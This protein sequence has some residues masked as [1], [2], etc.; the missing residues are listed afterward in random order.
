MIARAVIVLLAVVSGACAPRLMKLPAGPGAPA[1]D[2]SDALAEA[3][4]ACR[5]ATT[6]TAEIAV[7]GSA[8]GQRVRGRLLAGVG[9]PSSARIEAVAPFGQPLFIF[10]T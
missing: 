9:S 1:P 5:A 7:S 10:V 3:T 2:A 4:A 6:M 8:A